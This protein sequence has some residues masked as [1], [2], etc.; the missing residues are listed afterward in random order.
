MWEAGQPKTQLTPSGGRDAGLRYGG[1]HVRAMLQILLL[2]LLSLINPSPISAGTAVRTSE[3][4]LEPL[5]QTARS[6][7]IG[8]SARGR[9]IRATAVGDG[10]TSILVVGCIHGNE[11]AGRP[12]IAR[13]RSAT[14]P[15][16]VTLWLIDLANPD[17]CLA[18]TRQN[19]HGVDLNRNFPYR[20][21]AL[22]RGTYYSGRR[23]LSEPESQALYRFISRERPAVSIWY[24]QHARLVDSYGDARIARRYAGRV[25]LPYK[26]FYAAPGS[27]TRWQVHSFPSSTGM[28]V[29]LPAGSLSAAAVRR[30]AN[31]VLTL[32]R[33]EG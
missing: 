13:L 9:A 16:G 12:V 29:E 30:H 4:E 5:A 17:G 20:W 26:F 33:E 19:A 10:P 8:H 6:E 11:R 21:E 27:I 2:A 31:A 14:P 3:D 25:G 23:A 24:H 1:H 32:A 18:D 28:V 7:V 15:A 22:P